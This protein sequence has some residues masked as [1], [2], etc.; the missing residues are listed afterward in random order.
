MKQ[1]CITYT[2]KYE[3]NYETCELHQAVKTIFIL[4]QPLCF[5]FIGS[6][7]SWF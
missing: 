2:N 7:K 6:Q 5:N 4:M 3:Y 1:T